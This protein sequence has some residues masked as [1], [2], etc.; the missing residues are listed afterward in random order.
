MAKSKKNILIVVIDKYKK[1]IFNKNTCFLLSLILVNGFC[2]YIGKYFVNKEVVYQS[3]ILTQSVIP[4][5]LLSKKLQ[6]NMYKIKYYKLKIITSNEFNSRE[7]INIKTQKIIKDNVDELNKYININHTPEELIILNRLLDNYKI[8]F[9]LTN[10]N[11][12]NK[13]TNT[14]KLKINND[15]S[16]L[17]DIK[18]DIGRLIEINEDLFL[19]IKNNG[20]VLSKHFIW[21]FYVICIISITIQFAFIYI[22][23]ELHNKH[24]LAIRDSN[25]D[26]LT[27]LYNR[28]KA[29]FEWG[30]S[31]TDK[32]TII[33]GDIDNFKK[34]NDTYG[35]SAGDFILYEISCILKRTSRPSDIVIRMGGD[36]FVILVNNLSLDKTFLLTERIRSEVS[37]TS[38]IFHSN[39]KIKVTVSFGIAERHYSHQTFEDVYA[40]ADEKLYHAKSL[41][42]NKT[43][44]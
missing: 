5:I 23:C 28:R 9:L 29:S 31:I 15:I 30:G 22:L 39:E 17:S 43:S 21:Y 2:F 25:T 24:T 34:I 44:Y 42:G 10:K 14:Q 38:F 20:V 40:L 6:L 26:P 27:H 41:G 37:D 3:H 16:L 32:I 19:K 18:N 8:F 33:L 11:E 13:Q 12:D 7:L 35:H 1:H 4:K 36:E